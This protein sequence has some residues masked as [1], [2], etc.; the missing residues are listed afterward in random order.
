MCGL[1][2]SVFTWTVLGGEGGA[3]RNSV[4]EGEHCTH[5]SSCSS[6]SEVLASGAAVY[7]LRVYFT[8]TT[9]G[10]LNEQISP[11][12]T[13]IIW[14]LDRMEEDRTEHD[15]SGSIMCAY[16]NLGSKAG[17]KLGFMRWRVIHL[18]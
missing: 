3:A 14:Y 18:S 7:S 11:E 4:K 9:V 15:R 1:R 16:Y 12:K 17:V 6:C 13:N 2:L 5:S 8:F 10:A